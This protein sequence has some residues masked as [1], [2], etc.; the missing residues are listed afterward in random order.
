MGASL[1]H[2]AEVLVKSSTVGPKTLDSLGNGHSGLSE[3][4]VLDLEKVRFLG[5][6]EC[7]DTKVDGQDL[8]VEQQ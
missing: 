1:M 7:I 3:L 8:P 4:E 2:A 5:I 6:R